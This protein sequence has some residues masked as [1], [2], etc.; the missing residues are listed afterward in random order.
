MLSLLMLAAVLVLSGCRPH[1][2]QKIDLSD[3]FYYW[4]STADSTPR[5]A[6]MH[7]REF[8]KIEDKS[9][10]NLEHIMGKEPGFVWV[11]AEFV[12]PP[13]MRGQPLGL[14]IPYLRFA[15]MLWLNGNFIAMFG[16][17]P[18]HEQ[19]TLCKSHYFNFPVNVLDQS[20]GKNVIL[21]K[22]YT[23]G[24]SA[25]SSHAFIQ[26]SRYAYAA[27]EMINFMHS[28]VYMMLEGGLFFTACLYLFLF[29]TIRMTR[30]NFDYA[31]LNFFSM[32]FI[33]PFFA[34]E[35]P[36]Y[37]NAVIPYLV[38][39]KLTLCIP[40][41]WVFFLIASF[42]RSFEHGRFP[43]S[44]QIVRWAILIFQCAI[45]MV[46]PDY[47]A[48][49]AITL[50]MLCLCIVQVLI[51]VGVFIQSLFVPARRTLALVQLAGFSP[52]LITILVDLLLRVHDNTEPY[53]FITIFGW[54]ISII[55]FMIILS[56]RFAYT[57]FRNERISN[58]LQEEVNLRTHE[59][60][61]ANYELSILNE[62]LE[63]DKYR[64][65]M[66]LEMA[67]IVQKRFFPQPD[68]HFKGWEIAICY[69]PLA[70]VSGDLYDCYS[71][72]EVLNGISLFDVSGHGISASLVTMLAKNIISHAFQKGFRNKESMRTIL[73]KINNIIIYEKGEIDNYMTG[74]LCRF[75]K[76]DAPDK[77]LVEMA[78][79]G[80]P[81]PLLF[82]A[83]DA[84]VSEV[85]SNDY[86]S[87]YGAV[88]MRGIDVSFAE[89]DFNMAQGDVLVCYT[90]GLTESTNLQ[91]EQF[92]IE[93][94]KQIIRENGDR[95]SNEILKQITDQLLAFTS[96]K[97]LEDDI[98]I[99]IAKRTAA[100]FFEPEEELEFGVEDLEVAE[101][102][103][104]IIVP[105]DEAVPLSDVEP[106]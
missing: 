32:F 100:E 85:R 80:H 75:E 34:T 95:P 42:I 14:V 77:C 29:L 64:S 87:H 13:E 82:K 47:D 25:I 52:V 60:Q 36:L 66:D 93:R 30:E 98:T 68:K 21:I 97:S 65:D 46:M 96:E 20:G 6:M 31:G 54:Q 78:N 74:I 41:Y 69:E 61:D 44:L 55:V 59:L 1:T 84:S 83:E 19:S 57:Y 15:E 81:H 43:L 72:N 7:A 86:S 67:S 11:R 9:T 79:A 37:N 38:F 40:L 53:P 105:E 88:G 33:M 27:H 3:S 99:I 28:R 49:M 22:I 103:E 12:V 91:L 94:V 76:S 73:N 62:R 63:R 8:K 17:F 70:K 50:P 48:L 18:P 39:M 4:P 89:F 106:N 5:D 45:T 101:E 26:P 90:D 2:T 92:G 10:R 71:Y 24:Q 51:G 104:E 56:F 102:A 16:V 35:I 23:H 58:H